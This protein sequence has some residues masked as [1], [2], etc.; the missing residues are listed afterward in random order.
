MKT[1]QQRSRR[2]ARPL[3]LGLAASVACASAVAWAQARPA[4]KAPAPRERY[5]PLAT[6]AVQ[7]P[8]PVASGHTTKESRS[9]VD[10]SRPTGTGVDL[11]FGL[12][13]GYAHTLPDD[14]AMESEF[15]G[16]HLG[17]HG[18]LG[19]SY[20]WFHLG[21]GGGY[22]YNDLSGSFARYED[23]ENDAIARVDSP[24]IRTRAGFAEVLPQAAFGAFRI[25][26]VM[27]IPFG[28]ATVFS[29][30]P[31]AR[32]KTSVLGGLAL[33][34][35]FE[36]NLLL[37]F[38][39]LADL[40]IKER[41][42]LLGLLDF[43]YHVDIVKPH[44][45]VNE[46]LRVTVKEKVQ[47]TTKKVVVEKLVVK[48]KVRFLF[49]NKVVNFDTAK[50]DLLPKSHE[51]LLKVGKFL[52]SRSDVFT[53]LE[54]EGHTDTRGGREYNMGL[55]QARAQTVMMTFQEAGV[56]AKR[57]SAKGFG[58]DKPIDPSETPAAWEKNRRVEISFVGVKDSRALAAFLE[59]LGEGI[60]RSDAP[61]DAKPAPK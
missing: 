31:V 24:K 52:A 61:V 36:S 38:Q 16:Y 18:L 40:N 51:L 7:P 55:S 37:G 17:V 56:D 49:D 53:S 9:Y 50:A 41:Q 20:Q 54:I 11:S 58:P 10:E 44:T 23:E 48:E 8:K 57:M 22:L 47:T 46:S 30:A 12:L 21:L 35:K 4:R 33:G 59:S 45:K 2:S 60:S 5:N 28:T 29:P 15:S 19:V 42:V 13:G 43:R 3:A 6:P 32:S 1:A 27:Q 14:P 26:P 25:G 34:W 39:A